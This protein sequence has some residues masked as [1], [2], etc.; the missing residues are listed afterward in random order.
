MSRARVAAVMVAALLASC[1][2]DPTSSPSAPAT[3]DPGAYGA[4][5]ASTDHYI[6]APQRVQFGVIS[7]DANR[8][9]LL[10][11]SGTIDVE[12][13]PPDGA[14]GTPV[15]GTARYV[16][17]PGTQVT[18]GPPS[19]TAPDVGRG[20][21]QI[22]AA[23]DV[24]GTWTA[25]LSFATSSGTTT[26]PATLPV[27]DEPALPAP[28]QPAI[29]S[30]NLTVDSRDTQAVDSRALD[31][32]PIPDP[33]LHATTIRAAIEQGR[34]IVALFA[35]PV[36]CESRFCGPTTDALADMAAAGDPDAAYVHVEIWHD[37]SA[38]EV[39]AAAAEWL[40]REG[41]LSE[42]WLYLIDAEGIIT[43]RWSPLF[44]PDEVAAEL[45]AL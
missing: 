10:L 24:A 9:V 27:H 1:A 23:F 21:Y 31:G 38:G 45:A 39:N 4:Q 19:L 28:G 29:M 16:A 36:Y 14:G 2:G 42:P 5:V 43:D 41:S 11:T 18:D 22:D 25:D 35:T 44:D 40:L 32:A 33:E 30:R 17:A 37:F 8:G 34:P 12:L 6:D 13:T 7:E 20:V 26:V 3:G 15:R